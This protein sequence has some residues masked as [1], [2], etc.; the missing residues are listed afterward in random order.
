MIHVMLLLVLFIII[1]DSMSNVKLLM[2]ILL[3][4]VV[5]FTALKPLRRFHNTNYMHSSSANTLIELQKTL[6]R[7]EFFLSLAQQG[8]C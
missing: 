8:T 7:N 2:S 5:A 6:T 1:L 4:K 3:I